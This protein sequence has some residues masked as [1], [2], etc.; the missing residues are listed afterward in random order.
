[1]IATSFMRDTLRDLVEQVRKTPVSEIFTKLSNG[2]V[3]SHP[4]DR[5]IG[6]HAVSDVES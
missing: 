2:E 4:M 5:A 3:Y 6:R 1:M